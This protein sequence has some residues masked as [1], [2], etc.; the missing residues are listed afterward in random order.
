MRL[1]NRC[2]L[3]I[4]CDTLL[5]NLDKLSPGK[6]GLVPKD[7]VLL[8]KTTMTFETGESVFD[9]LR[10]QKIHYENVDARPTAP[11]TSR[12]SAISMNLTAANSPAGC[13]LSTAFLRG[14]AAPSIRWPMVTRSCLPIPA[15]LVPTCPWRRSGNKRTS[16]EISIYR[17]AIGSTVF[18]MGRNIGCTGG[19][20]W[21]I[22]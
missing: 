8:E 22:G 6:A 20:L 21:A 10:Q 17:G 13:T 1:R 7:G 11:P 5:K 2:T 19:M 12:A 3:E 16:P 14:W 9:V 4:R 15:T 18:L